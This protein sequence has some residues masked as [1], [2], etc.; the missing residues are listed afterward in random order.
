MQN[1]PNKYRFSNTGEVQTYQEQDESLIVTVLLCKVGTFNDSSGIKVSLTKEQLQGLV[2]TYNMEVEAEYHKIQANKKEPIGRIF[3]EKLLRKKTHEFSIDEVTLAPVTTE[4]TLHNSFVVGRVI[5]RLEFKDIS[6]SYGEIWG[7]L[8]ISTREYVDKVKGGILNQISLAFYPQSNKLEEVSFTIY[9]AIDGAQ[10]IRM[11]QNG[12]KPDKNILA[13]T[14][15]ELS[16][17]LSAINTE[18]TN[19]DN[20]LY[21]VRNKRSLER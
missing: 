12:I 9:G 13:N 6:D 5:G 3:L 15:G 18:I 2:N 11:S 7:K 21:T 16:K 4:H 19:L 8:F 14:I 17:K 10:I 20:Q 1:K